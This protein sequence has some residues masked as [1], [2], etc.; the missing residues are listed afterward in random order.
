MNYR[1]QQ[2]F[3]VERFSKKIHRAFSHRMHSEGES[4]IA[5]DEH[6]RCEWNR[7]GQLRLKLQPAHSR[8]EI[9]HHDTIKTACIG[10]LEK[11]FSRAVWYNLKARG[12][13]LEDQRLS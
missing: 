1:A 9:I 4:A 6:D 3:F 2:S 8:Q 7:T 12:V 10:E 11:F 5:A 13:K